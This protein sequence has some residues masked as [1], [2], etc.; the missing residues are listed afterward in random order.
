MTPSIVEGGASA[1]LIAPAVLRPH[2]QVQCTGM[3]PYAASTFCNGLINSPLLKTR[4]QIQQ[5]FVIAIAL[6]SA[7]LYLVSSRR[8]GLLQFSI[9]CGLAV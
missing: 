8:C 5:K 2:R 9:R 7:Q 3:T 1:R 6:C 4:L